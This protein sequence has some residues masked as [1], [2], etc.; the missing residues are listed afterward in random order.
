L[1]C[2]RPACL[3]YCTG[4]IAGFLRAGP[5][6]RLPLKVTISGASGFIGRRLLKLLAG[7]HHTLHVLSRHAGTNLPPGMALSVWDPVK[8]PPPEAALRDADA[9]I[10]LAG[11]PVAQRWSTEVKN[12]IRETRVT[13]TRHLVE[14]LGSLPQRPATLICASAIG[15]YGSR[16]D[17]ILNEA[18]AP[19][20]GFLPEVCAA[21][22]QEARAAEALG[23]RV[24]RI[25]VGLVLDR[26]G[27]ALQRMLPPFRAGAGGRLGSGRQWM[28]W[29]HLDDLIEMFRFALDGGLAGAVNGTAPDPVTNRD[30]TQALAAAL[31]RPALFPVPKIALR[32]VFGE[33]AEMLL[34]SQRVVPQAAEAAHFPFRYTRLEPALAAALQPQT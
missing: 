31:H 24:V 13:G 22:E 2:S 17:E 11:E 19:G 29:I 5:E 23:I 3:T 7:H 34:E 1:P 4:P 16:G 9:V 26:N 14:A 32:M 8:G 20:H 10:H 15:Y 18:S 30:F 25:R 33:M 27:G 6:R 12:R 21:W 28:S